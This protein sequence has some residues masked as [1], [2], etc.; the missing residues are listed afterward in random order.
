VHDLCPDKRRCAEH[1]HCLG[2]EAVVVV[3][4]LLSVSIVLARL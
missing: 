1:P 2:R 4:E 3:A